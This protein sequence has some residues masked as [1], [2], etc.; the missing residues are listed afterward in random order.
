MVSN[1]LSQHGC[2]LEE[3]NCFINPFHRSEKWGLYPLEVTHLRSQSY[4]IRAR[5][6]S[7]VN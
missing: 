2:D 4:F 3:K 5:I 6:I 1:A 7:Q